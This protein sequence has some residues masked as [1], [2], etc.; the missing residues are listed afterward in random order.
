MP[1]ISVSKILESPQALPF[2]QIH[3]PQY[4]VLVHF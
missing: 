4:K 1:E 3:L 2:A